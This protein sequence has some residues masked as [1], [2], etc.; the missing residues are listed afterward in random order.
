M[1]LQFNDYPHSID[2][3]SPKSVHYAKVISCKIVTFTSVDERSHNVESS[4]SSMQ[5]KK[6]PQ[7]ASISICLINL[8]DLQ[9]TIGEI[10]PCIYKENDYKITKKYIK[11]PKKNK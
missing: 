2:S 11:S 10:H 6:K 8:E 1:T 5:L 7:T 4:T 3:H 9:Y